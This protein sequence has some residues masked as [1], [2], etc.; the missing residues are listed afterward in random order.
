MSLPSREPAVPA[1]EHPGLD[2][3]ITLAISVALLLLWDS[4]WL[5]PLKVLVVYFH[6]GSHALAAVL[7]GGEVMHLKLFPGQGGEVM[8]RGGNLFIILT[9]GYLGSLVIGAA[10]FLLA[11]HTRYDRVW[12]GLMALGIL[13]LALLYVRQ[14]YALGFA[15]A[16][17][18]AFGA[19]A[20]WGSH[21]LNDIVLRI[22]GLT[23]IG[24]VPLDIYSDTLARPQLFSDARMLAMAFGGTTQMWGLAW[25]AAS[26]V[27]AGLCV[28]LSIPRRRRVQATG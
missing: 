1:A 2:L 10:L 15:L 27:I 12:T 24:Y 6:E 8:S 21:R 13:I 17:A 28:W 16:A 14:L 20:W 7:T 22:V 4:A 23:S 11:A 18:V 19:L 9:A 5:T 3:G 25:L 26:L